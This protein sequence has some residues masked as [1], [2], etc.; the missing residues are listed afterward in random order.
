M[1]ERH[2]GFFV[3]PN[4]VIVRARLKRRSESQRCRTLVLLF[5]NDNAFSSRF[6]RG[7]QL[8]LQEPEIA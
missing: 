3:Y 8:D 4:P 1:N 6:L 5:H 2:T 7:S